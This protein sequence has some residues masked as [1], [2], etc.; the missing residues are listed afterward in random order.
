LQYIYKNRP[1]VKQTKIDL[2]ESPETVSL[3]IPSLRIM[4]YFSSS[5]VMLAGILLTLFPMDTETWFAWTINSPLSAALL[6]A[7]YWG[8]FF[9][10]FMAA[11]EQVWVRARVALPGWIIFS[12]LTCI[13]TFMNLSYYHFDSWTGWTWVILYIAIPL[14]FG[15]LL[16][17]QLRARKSPDPPRIYPLPEWLRKPFFA[18]S[19]IVFVFGLALLLAPAQAA[20]IWP[21]P[22][23]APDSYKPGEIKYVVEPFVAVWLIT[24]GIVGFHSL[25]EDDFARIKP[26]MAAIAVVGACQFFSVLRFSNFLN[27]YTP[28]AWILVGIQLSFLA[29][30]TYGLIKSK[31]KLPV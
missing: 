15:I 2:Q 28:G 9:L 22:L 21:W 6:G 1:F 19:L 31:N 16:F 10:A 30:G 25:I 11:R 8:G 3:L 13:P 12:S 17:F 7:N 14:V 23:T 18:L 20:P 29:L 26:A 27:W 24:F 5:M 4:L